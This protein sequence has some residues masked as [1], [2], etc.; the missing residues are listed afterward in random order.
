MDC[1][2]RLLFLSIAFLKFIHDACIR[3]HLFCCKMA[4]HCEDLPHFVIHLFD[5][6]LS[7]FLVWLFQFSL[8]FSLF[9]HLTFHFE[10]IIGSHTVLKYKTERFH[11]PSTQFPLIETS[12]KTVVVYPNR[13]I[14][15]NTVKICNISITTRISCITAV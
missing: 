12:F 9:F 11:V 6:Y 7:Y 15:N 2:V 1:C 10:I 5:G 13:D 3:L 14:D 4:C 8:S